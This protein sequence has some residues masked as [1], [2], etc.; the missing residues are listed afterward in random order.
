MGEDAIWGESSTTG[1]LRHGIFVTLS[2][3][4]IVL[5]IDIVGVSLWE[6]S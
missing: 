4:D 2:G 6:R 3:E 1:A 5:F